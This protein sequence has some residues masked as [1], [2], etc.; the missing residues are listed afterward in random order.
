[1]QAHLITNHIPLFAAAFGALVLLGGLLARQRS[2]RTV[3]LLLCVV[4][5]LSGV[6][7][8]VTGEDAEHAL[9]DQLDAA[10]HPYLEA[11]EEAAKP[12][13]FP[14]LALGIL[15]AFCL[16][17]DLK[18]KKVA[19]ALC[20]VSVAVALGL[21]VWMMYAAHLGGQIRHPELRPGAAQAAPATRPTDDARP[22]SDDH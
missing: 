22:H 21:T 20:W 10:A 17:A 5:G 7:A 16:W 19:L 2:V 14:T 9:E 18:Q 3:G 15:A 12:L 4:A 1:M 13:M 11:H 8:H 6:P